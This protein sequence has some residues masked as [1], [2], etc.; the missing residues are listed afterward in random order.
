MKL[1]IPRQIFENIP[2]QNFMKL[3]PVGA[4]LFRADRWIDMKRTVVFRHL[5]K[6]PKN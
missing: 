4:E 1:E 5:T 6:V 3:H 2:K